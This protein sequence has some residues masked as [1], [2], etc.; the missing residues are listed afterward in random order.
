M[1]P[2]FSIVSLVYRIDD[3]SRFIVAA[4]GGVASWTKWGTEKSPAETLQQYVL[5]ASEQ[6]R[7]AQY[8]GGLS[9]SPE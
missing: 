8:S 6:W 3:R 4:P 9:P 1:R 5:G 7:F 2:P